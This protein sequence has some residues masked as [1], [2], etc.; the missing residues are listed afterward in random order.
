MVEKLFSGR[1]P[2]QSDV[3]LDPGCGEG[4]FIEGVLRYC[5]LHELQAPHVVGVETD[6]DLVK[7]ARRKF[8]NSAVEILHQDYLGPQIPA[9]F[10]IGNPPYVPITGLTDREKKHYRRLFK[11]AVS[12]FDLYLL[13]FERSLEN[14]RRNG[15]LCFVTPEKYEYVHTAA[16]LRRMFV[17]VCI[18]QIVHIDEDSFRGLVTYP[19]ITT[20]ENNPLR[21]GEAT[22]VHLRH[23]SVILVHLPKDGSAWTGAIE[24]AQPIDNDGLTLGNVCIRVSAGIATGA[25]SIY[26]LHRAKIPKSLEGFSHPTISGKQLNSEQNELSATQDVMLTP[27]DETGALLPEA[28]L[29]KLLT[30]LKPHKKI[31]EQRTCVKK[32]NHSKWYR[33]HDSV[34][35]PDIM[36]PKILCKD[37]AREPRFWMDRAGLVVPRHTVYY[38]VPK[39]N[40]NPD[41]LLIYLNS[42]QAKSWLKAHCQRAANGFY[43]LQTEVIKQLP[44]PVE[45]HSKLR[46]NEQISML[47]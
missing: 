12:R 38:I 3:L 9:D 34:P 27:Y 46:T 31:L 29:E 26:V 41:E 45:L 39:E 35:L 4:S 40:T 5:E 33:F 28:K 15:R 25:D 23:G 22:S 10:I 42:D 44:I 24:N 14:L 18:E 21:A 8:T 17:S 20:V 2:K 1:E 36:R 13:F 37:I 16:S 47:N 6:A 11:T 7:K 32:H 43:R 30:Y 19:V